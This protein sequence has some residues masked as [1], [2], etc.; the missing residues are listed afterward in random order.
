[1]PAVL[2]PLAA[3]DLAIR[4]LGRPVALLEPELVLAPVLELLVRGHP[5]TTFELVVDKFTHE[6]VAG[7]KFEDT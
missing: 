2:L 3:V 1:M 5:P 4:L 7:F 6:H